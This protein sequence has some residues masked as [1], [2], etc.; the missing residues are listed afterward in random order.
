MRCPSPGWTTRP[1]NGVSSP[2]PGRPTS[3]RSHGFARWFSRSACPST[4]QR[5]RR[6][7]SPSVTGWP[8]CADVWTTACTAGLPQFRIGTPPPDAGKL[9]FPVAVDEMDF[10]RQ[11]K[12]LKSLPAEV[13]ASLERAQPYQSPEGPRS[14]LL[15]WLHELARIDRHRNLHIGVGR[16]GSHRVQVALPNGIIARFDESVKPYTF[17][18]DRTVI[19]RFTT[20]APVA[21]DGHR[22]QPRSRHRSRDL[23]VGRLHPRRAVAAFAR[24]NALHRAL[25]PQPPGEHGEL[26]PGPPAR[27]LPHVHA[28]QLGTPLHG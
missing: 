1:T 15:F 21:A 19:G 28:R 6:W 12:R 2:R 3:R 16:I 22:L 17:I 23:G 18:N 20:S 11:V 10:R 27:R 9:Q 25:P 5:P 24:T 26:L 14:N 4:T 8:R 7:R 13:I